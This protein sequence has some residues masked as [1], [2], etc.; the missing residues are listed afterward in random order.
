MALV[1]VYIQTFSLAQQPEKR[2]DISFNC[3]SS[4]EGIWANTSKSGQSGYGYNK[5][6]TP[7]VSPAY[8]LTLDYLLTPKLGI[9]IGYSYQQ[10][11]ADVALERYRWAGPEGNSS[12]TVDY[13]RSHLGFRILV[14]HRQGKNLQTYSGFRMGYTYQKFSET[15]EVSYTGPEND[16][17][18][19]SWAKSLGQYN[20]QFI[21]MG[22]KGYFFRNLGANIELAI[23]APHLLSF[24]INYRL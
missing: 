18:W 11:G 23:G 22:L 2:W 9:G 6:V 3:A 20:P 21:I 19:L 16:L 24:G 1:F 13:F 14:Y 7:R 15:C 12:Y 17:K 8:Q 5:I 4:M 10:I